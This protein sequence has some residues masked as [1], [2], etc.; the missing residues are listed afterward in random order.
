MATRY[1]ETPAHL[2]AAEAELYDVWEKNLKPLGVKWTNGVQRFVLIALYQCMPGSKSQAE[3]VD[4]F[5]ANGLPPAACNRQARHMSELG[6]P[7]ASGNKGVGRFAYDGSIPR[8]HIRLLS[9]TQANNGRRRTHVEIKKADWEEKLEIYRDFGCA[10]C[11]QQFAFYERG[12]LDPTKPGTKDNIVPLC[13]SCNNYAMKHNIAY[14]LQEGSL[15]ARQVAM[16]IG[17]MRDAGMLFPGDLDPILAAERQKIEQSLRAELRVP[18]HLGY[19]RAGSAAISR[20]KS[21]RSTLRMRI[22]RPLATQGEGGRA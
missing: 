2:Q 1:I 4:W 9:V 3:L 7:I 10:D 20:L 6:W 12:H 21:S 19:T 5:V 17:E 13:K 11:H 22:S 16:T 18:G 15:R 14:E 8:D